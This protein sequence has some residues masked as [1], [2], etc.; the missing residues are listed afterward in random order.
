MNHNIYFHI[1][2]HKTGT[3][4][5]QRKIFL[6]NKKFNLLNDFQ[7]PWHDE[8]IRKFIL[9]PYSNINYSK[10][11]NKINSRCDERINIISA[12]RLSGHPGSGGYDS[13]EIAR[14]IKRLYPKANII[15]NTRGKEDFKISCY[16]QLVKEGYC[17]RYEDFVDSQNWKL[18]GPNKYYFNQ[19]RLVKHYISLF[20]NEN[21]LSQNFETFKDKPELFMEKL[22]LFFD[23][24]SLSIQA[25]Q[26]V[27]NKSLP[28]KKIR[29]LRFVNKFR[30]T[31][32]NK[33]PLFSIE[34]DIC[35]L[36]SKIISFSFSDKSFGDE[37]T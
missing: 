34:K 28:N 5:L 18:A 14:K 11:R 10:F 24:N 12:E 36:L 29:S 27:V 8:I 16:K 22:K 4:F 9:V 19:D 7:T 32:F 25:S 13:Y 30:I 35:F 37:K 23:L 33:F 17:G 15:I 1:G 21:V 20:G 31:E 2:F 26:N 3:T 6:N